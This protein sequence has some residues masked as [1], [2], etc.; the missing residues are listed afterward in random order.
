MEILRTP[1]GHQDDE[2]SPPPRN[3]FT[4]FVF[5]ILFL[6]IGMVVF[7]I[8]GLVVRNPELPNYLLDQIVRHFRRETTGS[9][10]A[11]KG[12][13]SSSENLKPPPLPATANEC[14]N[15]M[16]YDENSL[17]ADERAIASVLNGT[18]NGLVGI[19]GSPRLAQLFNDQIMAGLKNLQPG[20]NVT[21]IRSAVAECHE[22]ANTAIEF[23]QELPEQLAVKL[24]AAGVSGS[25]A[26]Q[27]AEL[28]A[29][30]A[31]ARQNISYAANV[32]LVCKNVTT[33][34]D[35]LSKSS[36]KWKRDSNGGVQF[37]SKAPFEQYNAAATGLNSAVKAL[38]GG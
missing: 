24:M 25:L 31:Q 3:P 21:A 22:T 36:T 19:R 4:R 34:V 14:L 23:Y 6:V 11:G 9:A 15:L 32:N 29:E 18:V 12:Y 10:T 37:T 17:P 38:N 8:G 2:A 35:L 7:F 13:V 27:T 20:G 28:F 33:M 16:S 30:R 26:H 5:A 1:P